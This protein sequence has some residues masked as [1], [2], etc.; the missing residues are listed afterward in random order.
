MKI[1]ITG[2]AGFIG[3]TIARACLEANHRVVVVDNLSRGK[4]E[5]LP[6]GVPL[7][8]ADI[9]DAQKLQEIFEHEQP[10][11]VSHHA[12]L[13]SVRESAQV[14]ELYQNVNWLGTANVIRASTPSV[15]K[16]IFASSGGAIYGPAARL[17]LAEDSPTQPI[18]PY[19]E[20]KRRAEQLFSES[21]LPPTVIL[22]YGN[23]YG[24]GQDSLGTNGVIA[25]FASALQRGSRPV[26]FGDGRQVRDYVF[27][28]DVARANLLAMGGD[29][30]GIFN[31]ASGEGLALL[32][33]YQMIA[34]EMN[35][36]MEPEFKPS[37]AF[38]VQANVLDISRARKILGWEPQ[39]D[40]ERG[41]KLTL[42][43]I[44]AQTQTTVPALLS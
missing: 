23:V 4:R 1:L 3:S 19:G 28:E 6:V 35:R 33:I 29:V 18:S 32:Q 15:R 11:I 9:R 21:G 39:V 31:I 14:P 16:M 34:N 27:V 44:A 5:N 38:E 2:G 10:E 8:V 24:P 12:A 25:I 41:L 42:N 20:S 7:H 13:V 22:R 40:F 26:V 37:F 36:H 30:H 17:P 43:A